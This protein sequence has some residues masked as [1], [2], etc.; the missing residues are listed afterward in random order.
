MFDS[1]EDF[2]QGTIARATEFP[3][4]SWFTFEP[5]GQIYLRA[6]KRN[7]LPTLDVANI[8]VD[9]AQRGQGV[10][11]KLLANIEKL[12]AEAGFKQVYAENVLNEKLIKFYERKGYVVVPNLYKPDYPSML[13]SL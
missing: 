7:E 8:S 4:R 10:Y 3:S 9:G 1:I 2:I 6:T 13:K 5:G 11:T 12:A